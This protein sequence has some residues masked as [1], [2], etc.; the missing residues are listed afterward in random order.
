M[1]A[2]KILV[3]GSK[4]RMG[5]AI[6]E[7]AAFDPDIEV[8]S[9]IDVGDSLADALPP[10]DTVID[11]SSHL[12]TTELVESCVA[13]GKSLVIGT[14]GHTADEMATVQNASTSIAIVMAP[15]YSVGVNTLFWL[16]QK[17]AEILGNNFDLEVLEMHHRLKTD[18]PSGTAKRLAESLTEVRKLDY[19]RDTRHGRRGD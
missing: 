16:T 12:F 6:I 3:S 11:F 5:Q 10:C 19:E 1:S 15:N 4:G 17:A 7:C 14:T 8:V 13:S 9:E 2:Q 18:A